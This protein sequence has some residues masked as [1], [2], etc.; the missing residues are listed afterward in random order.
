MLLLDQGATV[1]S[2][3][4]ISGR[5]SRILP[6]LDLKWDDVTLLGT[7]DL[8]FAFLV[9][10]SHARFGLTVMLGAAIPLLETLGANLGL[11]DARDVADEL[12]ALHVGHDAA[13]YVGLHARL[14]VD[15]EVV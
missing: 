11:A 1:V 2:L 14:L 8:V 10:G 3:I 9:P 12:A 7:L 13:R 6:C 5:L 15:L 4:K